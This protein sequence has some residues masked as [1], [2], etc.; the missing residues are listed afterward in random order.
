M[1]INI[2]TKA[3]L[4]YSPLDV[5]SSFLPDQKVDASETLR[6]A[7]TQALSKLSREWCRNFVNL[8]P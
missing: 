7:F 1:S 5:N 2:D 4:N 8:E 3:L 6:A